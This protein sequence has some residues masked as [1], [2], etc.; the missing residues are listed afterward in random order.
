M[1]KLTKNGDSRGRGAT[2]S[3]LKAGDAKGKPRQN[4]EEQILN[5]QAQHQG[6]K[7]EGL[8]TDFLNHADDIENWRW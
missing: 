3:P 5:I 4:W 1:A 8:L 7:D 2:T 6:Q